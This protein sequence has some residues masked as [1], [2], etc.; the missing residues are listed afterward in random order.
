MSLATYDTDFPA[1]SV[2]FC[3]HPLAQ[4]ILAC[5]TYRLTE[6]RTSDGKQLRLGKCLVFDTAMDDMCVKG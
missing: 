4:N 5:G 1:D 3:P 6:E 2:E